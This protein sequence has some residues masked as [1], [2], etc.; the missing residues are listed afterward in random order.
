MT[1]GRGRGHVTT[2]LSHDLYLNFVISVISLGETRH[3]TF[4]VQ[5]DTDE[6]SEYMITPERDVCRVT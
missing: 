2:P 3:F 4:R 5:T 1:N 6:S